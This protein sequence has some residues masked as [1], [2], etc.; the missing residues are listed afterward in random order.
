M[1]VYFS[2][3]ITGGRQD[4]PVYQSIVDA[5]VADGH[6]VPTAHLSD[7][8]ILSLETVIDPCDVYKRDVAWVKNCDALVAEV[9]TPSHG[10][11]YEIAL[12]ESLGKPVFCCYLLGSRVSKMILGNTSPRF[13]TCGY[14]STED[15]IQK[16]KVFLKSIARE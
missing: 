13:V 4:Q 2:C 9:T 8:N 7:K 11:G 1:N 12:A 3:S 15:V 14:S 16:M 6:I 5:L 10:V